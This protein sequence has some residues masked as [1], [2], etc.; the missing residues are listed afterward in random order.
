MIISDLSKHSDI[1]QD[2]YED[3]LM[4]IDASD[5]LF[6]LFIAVSDDNIL[7]DKIIEK[8]E[9]D[10]TPQIVSYHLSLMTEK[11]SLEEIISKLMLEDIYFQYKARAVFTVYGIE[12]LDFVNLASGK[13]QQ[14]T[15]FG[16]LQWTRENF[17]NFP[18]PIVIWVNSLLLEKLARKAPDFWDWRKGVFR[19]LPAQ[20]TIDSDIVDTLTWKLCGTFEVNQT[21]V[22]SGQSDQR[23]F[24][25]NYA[26]HV[27]DVL[28]R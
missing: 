5:G 10:L 1:D 16:Y 21:E 27:D 6:S 20:N 12:E 17:K 22:L 19:F 15:F 25:T 3:L 4:S 13:S 26:E 18:Y 8:Y 9:S 11:P 24:V 28:Y 7:R 23:A 14:D 2:V